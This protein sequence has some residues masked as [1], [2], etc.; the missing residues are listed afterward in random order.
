VSGAGG[1]LLLRAGFPLVLAGAGLSRAARRY[2]SLVVAAAFVLQP[3][4][5]LAARELKQQASNPISTDDLAGVIQVTQLVGNIGTL[6]ITSQTLAGA[7]TIDF[8][9]LT[10]P[11]ASPSLIPPTPT[12]GPF[13][14]V[15]NAYGT[16]YTDPLVSLTNTDFLA[17]ID[18]NTASPTYKKIIHVEKLPT[19][20]NEPHH[21]SVSR[22]RTRIVAGGLLSFLRLQV[23]TYVTVL[24]MHAPTC[25]PCMHA[26]MVRQRTHTTCLRIAG[27]LAV[28]VRCGSRAAHLR[29]CVPCHINQHPPFVALCAAGRHLLFRHCLRPPPPQA[30]QVNSARQDCRH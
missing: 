19:I 8:N 26:T 20:G 25:L 29:Q 18:L 12:T 27:Q 10:L 1:F 16:S 17:V 24:H 6:G 30:A 2:L 15:W 9:P 11:L 21:I 5:A 7:V 3:F 4:A 28:C 22:D 23:C 14:Y 13:L